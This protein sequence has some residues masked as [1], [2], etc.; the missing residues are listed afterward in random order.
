LG[1]EF[2][3]WAYSMPYDENHPLYDDTPPESME[4]SEADTGNV[5]FLGSEIFHEDTTTPVAVERDITIGTGEKIFIPLLNGEASEIER[6]QAGYPEGQS[7]PDVVD[8]WFWDENGEPYYNIAVKIDD[9]DVDNPEQYFATSQ[10][11]EFGPLPAGSA[12]EKMGYDEAT[13]G[14]TSEFAAAGYY[15]LLPPLPPGEHTIE[16]VASTPDGSW[17]QSVIY[18]ITVEPGNDNKAK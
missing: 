16:I 4:S 14:A 17:S 5:L 6:E 9:E 18:N 8:S 15:L 13:E 11:D 2:W 1:A 10:P 3:Q 12:L 7:L